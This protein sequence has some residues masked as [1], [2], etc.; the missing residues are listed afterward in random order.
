MDPEAKLDDLDKPGVDDE[1]NGV[2]LRYDDAYQYQNIFGPL[3]K[4]EADYDKKIKES[5]T[6]DS[7]T[8]HWDIGLNKKRIARFPFPKADNGNPSFHLMA[9]VRSTYQ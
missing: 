9:K 7:I 2:L 5:Q 8:V 4:L 6:Q 1:P 3:V